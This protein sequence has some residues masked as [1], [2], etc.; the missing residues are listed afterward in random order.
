MR[1]IVV[2]KNWCRSVLLGLTALLFL[3]G[4]DDEEK[5]NPEVEVTIPE[6][7]DIKVKRPENDEMVV[8]AE[9]LAVT[10]V[11][12]W[13]LFGPGARRRW[14]DVVPS[15]RASPGVT[16]GEDP[17]STDGRPTSENG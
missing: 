9:L 8:V 16:S 6:G 17:T 7:V 1:H 12:L 11:V 5:K 13:A 3:S 15:N 4:C 14:P 2:K 10:G